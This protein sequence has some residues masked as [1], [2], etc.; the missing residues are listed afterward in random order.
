MDIIFKD[1][2]VEKFGD[3]YYNTR[4]K[5]Q[6]MKIREMKHYLDMKIILIKFNKATYR[7]MALNREKNN[8]IMPDLTCVMQALPT[9]QSA[10]NRLIWYTYKKVST[11]TKF[12]VRKI[13]INL[14]L[15][16]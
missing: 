16:N 7:R 10:E 14:L 1:G 6:P 4:M 15:E 3:K 8:L 13:K 2:E 9:L 11:L 5:E 12:D